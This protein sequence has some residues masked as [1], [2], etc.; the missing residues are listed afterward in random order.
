MTK[1][2]ARVP[3]AAAAMRGLGEYGFRVLIA[4]GAYSNPAGECWPSITTIANT[5]GLPR[6]KAH[7]I[8]KK[9]ETIGLITR[10]PGRAGAVMRYI[11]K[12]DEVSPHQGTALVTSPGD[13][14]FDDVTSPGDT[15]VTSP[16]DKVSPHQGT[17]QPIEAAQLKQPTLL[18]PDVDDESSDI[19]LAF[20][21][22]NAMAGETGL[23]TVRKLTKPLRT[24]LKARLSDA[25]GI[26]GW[27]HALTKIQDSEFLRGASDSGWRAT[28]QWAVKPANFEKIMAG[29]YDR[30][31]ARRSKAEE[32]RDALAELAEEVRNG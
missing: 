12:H 20:E 6:R 29:N 4:L 5:S 21:A 1:R 32:T 19:D 9:L 26:E 11:I 24:S 18:S 25:G 22:W 13:T 31:A 27:R 15:G 30:G 2:F 14:E 8:V 23:P 10:C 16:G 7:E 3:I 28:F 17:E